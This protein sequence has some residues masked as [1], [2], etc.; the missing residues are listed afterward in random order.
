[1]RKEFEYVRFVLAYIIRPKNSA[2]GGI[3]YI[4][5]F[6][7]KWTLTDRSSNDKKGPL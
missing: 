6:C 1:M 7:R 2:D 3:D 5:F 4:I